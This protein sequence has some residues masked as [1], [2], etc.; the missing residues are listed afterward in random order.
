MQLNTLA[1]G[2]LTGTLLQ[3]VQQ[4]LGGKTPPKKKK[5][6]RVCPDGAQQTTRPKKCFFLG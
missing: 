2:F 4:S 6:K 5:K 1:V 3:S